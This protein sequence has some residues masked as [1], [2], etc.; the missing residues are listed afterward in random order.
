MTRIIRS[1]SVASFI[2]Y[3]ILTNAAAQDNNAQLT[4]LADQIRSQGYLCTNPISAERVA[5]E[6][7]QNEPVYL[8]TCEDAT[9]KIRLVPDQAASVTKI[10]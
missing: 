4:I 6:S 9:Y 8:L 1:F 10:K 3:A 5:A 2:V 7:V